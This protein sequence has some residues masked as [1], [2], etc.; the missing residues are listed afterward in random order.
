MY[1][2]TPSHA[3]AVVSA[4]ATPAEVVGDSSGSS[5]GRGDRRTAF[6]RFSNGHATGGQQQQSLPKPTP[7]TIRGSAH[8]GTRNPRLGSE[9]R[10]VRGTATA[11]S[12]AHASKLQNDAATVVHSSAVPNPA[13]PSDTAATAAAA[14]AN[15]ATTL[16]QPLTS[17]SSSV[18]AITIP[19][20]NTAMPIARPSSADVGNK[21]SGSPVGATSARQIH[22]ITANITNA[23]P[24]PGS[25]GSVVP[26]LD[27]IR[28]EVS[29]S[30]IPSLDSVV[31][32]EGDVAPEVAEAC[33]GFLQHLPVGW[34]RA[35]VR[36]VTLQT[37]TLQ[38]PP[39]LLRAPAIFDTY[40]ELRGEVAATLEVAAA[41]SA[42]SARAVT[43]TS[44]SAA[45]HS[46]TSRSTRAGGG[47]GNAT[48]KVDAH[49]PL[50]YTVNLQQ[51]LLV[52]PALLRYRMHNTRTSKVAELRTG[53][54]NNAQTAAR[55][56]ASVNRYAYLPHVQRDVHFGAVLAQGA[57]RMMMP[58]SWLTSGAAPVRGNSNGT[59]HDVPASGR[60][61]PRQHVQHAS[62]AQALPPRTDSNSSSTTV[63]ATTPVL[64]RTYTAV[65]FENFTSIF[66]KD[67]FDIAQM[68]RHGSNSSSNYHH[69]SRRRR[70]IT[71]FF[72]RDF[73]ATVA[74]G[75][76]EAALFAATL[77]PEFM[78][79]LPSFLKSPERAVPLSITATLHHLYSVL[80]LELFLRA[81]TAAALKNAA[82]AEEMSAAAATPHNASISP[83]SNN[84][85]FTYPTP[86]S[87]ATILSLAP[88]EAPPA[89]SA[90]SGL[91]ALRGPALEMGM[92][93]VRNTIVCSASTPGMESYLVFLNQIVYANPQSPCERSSGGTT[94]AASTSP[95]TC[96]ALVQL[97]EDANGSMAAPPAPAKGQSSRNSTASNGAA[98]PGVF[99]MPTMKHAAVEMTQ[100][101]TWVQD[102][103]SHDPRHGQPFSCHLTFVQ[104]E[105]PSLAPPTLLNLGE[106]QPQGE[107]EDANAFPCAVVLATADL[108]KTLPPPEV[109]NLLRIFYVLDRHAQRVMELESPD[110]GTEEEL[111]AA[112]AATAA[113]K[114]RGSADDAE[115]VAETSNPITRAIPF[116]NPQV[117]Q[118]IASS[119]E[120]QIR[121][122]L[123]RIP[124]FKRD[125][126]KSQMSLRQRLLSFFMARLHYYEE[127]NE[128]HCK[129]EEELQRA[130]LRRMAQQRANVSVSPLQTSK[131]SPALASLSSPSSSSCDVYEVRS[132]SLGDAL[133]VALAAEAVTAS[134]ENAA[135]HTH[136]NGAGAGS[137]PARQDGAQGSLWLHD[138]TRPCCFGSAP[139]SMSE[140]VPS[141]EE[142]VVPAPSVVV[143]LVPQRDVQRR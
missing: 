1:S 140:L 90:A 103:R 91:P 121:A 28:T 108:W 142:N 112:A 67:R 88:S 120:P 27:H 86:G 82:A 35:I 59:P 126:G 115:N 74:I 24:P 116:P 66:L 98:T 40:A 97:S 138:S 61:S 77:A 25:K 102:V 127:L 18:R 53:F 42:K 55:T 69:Y 104:T 32:L 14:A 46:Y 57:L 15:T 129:T 45:R 3:Q 26:M 5:S 78:V 52:T 70:R 29:E 109:S 136:A 134:S 124:L 128:R 41:G 21:K 7:P 48:G 39:R 62:T 139:G 65:S 110:Y 130:E 38:I 96:R 19:S 141:D 51:L 60:F 34:A 20:P 56:E 10:G 49:L 64:T 101:V 80:T 43:A 63:T 12:P 36:A 79:G 123:E 2:T 84:A 131:S 37:V 119:I 81:Y 22:P 11:N 47:G 50:L 73:V 118:H 99:E 95:P 30:S 113:A 87:P 33:H 137:G 17:Q 93:Y 75:Q 4:A 92:L 106:P 117:R 100:L 13:P 133:A 94:A 132:K 114:S 89:S 16:H 68:E 107:V 23:S 71:P 6:Q 58:G 72:E 111:A 76:E 135:Q 54:R 122:F 44:T 83:N 143:L 9:E 8:G 125:S 31:G 105:I 85:N